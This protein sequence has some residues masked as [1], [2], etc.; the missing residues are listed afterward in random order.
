MCV[1][2]LPKDISISCLK[3]LVEVGTKD[4]PLVRT[5]NSSSVKLWIMYLLYWEGYVLEVVTMNFM[6]KDLYLFCGKK[7]LIDG[8][9]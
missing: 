8:G 1:L 5:E 4:K 3:I 2:N 6:I 7:T 9:V